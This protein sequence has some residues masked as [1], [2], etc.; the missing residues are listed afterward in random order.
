VGAGVGALIGTAIKT[1]RWQEVP[2]DRVR[3]SFGPQRNGR[4]GFGLSV[5]F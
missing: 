4:F 3:V 5:S 2:L 1:E